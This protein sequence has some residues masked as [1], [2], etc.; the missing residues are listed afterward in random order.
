MYLEAVKLARKGSLSQLFYV[1]IVYEDKK[2][3]RGVIM[4]SNNHCLTLFNIGSNMNK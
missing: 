4:T 1:L 3:Y 2:L